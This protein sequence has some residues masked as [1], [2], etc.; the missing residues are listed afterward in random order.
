MST[1]PTSL[2]LL[3]DVHHIQQVLLRYPIALDTRQLEL[4]G[5]VFA[6]DARIDLHSIGVFDRDGYRRLCE[7]ALFRLD[8]TQ[9]LI[10]PA[11]VTVDGDQARA[12]SYYIAQHA[13]NDLRPDP[14]LMI[15]GW[16]DDE[17][18]RAT[19]RWL[20]T[21]RVGTSVWWDGN[22]AVLGSSELAGAQEWRAGRNCPSWLM[23]I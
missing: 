12:R 7:Q 8:A 13:R 3:A 16:Y 6:T 2:E 5:D 10:G 9:H 1:T 21:S 19:G 23:P 17:L 22:P 11:A 15:G 18:A 14:V 4:F 20:I